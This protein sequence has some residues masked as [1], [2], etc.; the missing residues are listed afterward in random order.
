M[1]FICMKGR[2][3]ERKR[4]KERERV[5]CMLVYSPN[6]GKSQEP[7]AHPGFPLGE[8]RAR[9]LSQL[10]SLPGSRSQETGLE[11]EQPDLNPEF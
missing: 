7:G 6:A 8:Q 9:C 11:A 5:L 10:S 2:A 4:T 1:F 3:T